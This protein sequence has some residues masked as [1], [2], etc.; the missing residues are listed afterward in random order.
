MT[1]KSKMS[2]VVFNQIWQLDLLLQSAKSQ[3]SRAASLV[4]IKSWCET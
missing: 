3:E 4:L 1:G 2:L